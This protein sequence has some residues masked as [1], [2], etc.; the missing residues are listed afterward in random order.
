[1]TFQLRLNFES[2]PGMKNL[3]VKFAAAL[4]LL[5]CTATAHAGSFE[6]IRATG[7]ILGQATRS[8]ITAPVAGM[9]VEAQLGVSAMA[10][11]VLP[12]QEKPKTHWPWWLRLLALI[13]V[14]VFV[15]TVA[16][17]MRGKPGGPGPNGPI[18]Q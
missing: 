7:T 16:R 10:N 13:F 8:R 6:K 14:L 15:R 3:Q 18:T 11:L 2:T 4:L 1:M 12:P 5:L 17:S 9:T